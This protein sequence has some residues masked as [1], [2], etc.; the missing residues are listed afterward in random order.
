MFNTE[1]SNKFSIMYI[2][3]EMISIMKSI[4]S[5]LGSRAFSSLQAQAPRFLSLGSSGLGSGLDV[6]A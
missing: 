3:S 4:G 6:G 2:I 1:K 5:R